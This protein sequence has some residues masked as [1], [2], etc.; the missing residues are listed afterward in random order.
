MSAD[1]LKTSASSV[2]TANIIP[3]VVINVTEEE[4]LSIDELLKTAS[5]PTLDQVRLGRFDCY[6]LLCWGI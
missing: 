5:L 4:H 2:D 6:F 3:H 1:S